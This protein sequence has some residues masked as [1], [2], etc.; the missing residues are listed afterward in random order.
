MTTVIEIITDALQDLSIYGPGETVSADDA[1]KCLRTLNKM[2]SQWQA[3]KLYVPGL[4]DVS[5]SPTGAVSYAIGPSATINVTLPVQIDSAFYRLN[6]I[7][8]PVTV[9]TSFEDYSN[10][11][12]K[13]I[14]GTI[15]NAIFYE[16]SYP[17]GTIYIWPQ[18]SAGEIHL[19]TRDVLTQ[20]TFLTDDINVPAE[21]ALAMQLSLEEL[22]ARTYGKVVTPDLKMDAKNARKVVKRNNLNLPIL[23]QPQE[24]LSNGRFSI[25]S[26]Q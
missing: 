20:Y 3:Q 23:G 1:Q 16:R 17:Q 14:A 21:Y 4:Q 12:L 22:V 19:I 26:G 25:Y 11:T 5:F 2:L 24:V 7:D 8:Y 13:T 9:I 6:N 18:T 10:I 15:P